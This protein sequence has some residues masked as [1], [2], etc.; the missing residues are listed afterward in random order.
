[1]DVG[2]TDI[3]YIELDS[4]RRLFYARDELVARNM[5]EKRFYKTEHLSKS[6]LISG[7][8]LN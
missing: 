7:L 1:M 5:H 8:K 4:G 3:P 2:K 6:D